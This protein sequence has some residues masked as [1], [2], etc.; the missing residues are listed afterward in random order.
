MLNKIKDSTKASDDQI[1]SNILNLARKR[2][3][4]FGST[5]NEVMMM[6][7][8]EIEQRK[9]SGSNRPITWD[10]V[11]HRSLDNQRYVPANQHLNVAPVLT[12]TLSGPSM[13]L[14]PSI[15]NQM[16]SALTQHDTNQTDH[17][18]GDL[19]NSFQETKKSA[20]LQPQ[21][22]PISSEKEEI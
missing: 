11:P 12:K 16:S 20:D 3:E 21:L 17:F 10:T 22:P 9:I 14:P 2:P 6:V 18:F 15:F 4:V 13:P 5:N 1:T 8:S 7:S 19:T